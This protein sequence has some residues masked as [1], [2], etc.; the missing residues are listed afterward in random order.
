MYERFFWKNTTSLSL[1][2]SYIKCPDNLRLEILKKM[3]SSRCQLILTDRKRPFV[4]KICTC[5][6][7]RFQWKVN[8][9]RF[10]DHYY[11]MRIT[12]AYYNVNY[13]SP[14]AGLYY[15][16]TTKD[17]ENWSLAMNSILH[18][19]YYFFNFFFFLFKNRIPPI[20]LNL[21]D[22]FWIDLWRVLEKSKGKKMRKSFSTDSNLLSDLLS[23]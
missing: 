13:R 2:I 12:A 10:H 22:R 23:H 15:N 3:V 11:G 1:R 6:A 21:F 18:R 9:L 14:R 19:I 7:V 5:F 4:K 16:N 8:I 17:P 20:S